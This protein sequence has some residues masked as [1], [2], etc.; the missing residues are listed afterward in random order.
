M[1]TLLL[2]PFMQLEPKTPK[3]QLFALYC[4]PCCCRF[5]G[6]QEEEP[7]TSAA[8]AGAA[9]KQSSLFAAGESELLDGWITGVFDMS[10]WWKMI[11]SSFDLWRIYF[12]SPYS[13][14]LGLLQGLFGSR[15]SF[16]GNQAFTE[17]E[18][19]EERQDGG[20]EKQS[21]RNA[22]SWLGA[23]P[24]CLS[25]TISCHIHVSCS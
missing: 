16:P 3:L 7:L 8:H 12:F 14:N 21:F 6:L 9:G 19:N 22:V 25:F 15:Q 1:V 18:R 24:S 4:C 2:S 13:W 17:G 11:H 20:G 10:E 5:D 23:A